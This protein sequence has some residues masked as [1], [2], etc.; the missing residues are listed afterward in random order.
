[1]HRSRSPMEQR[2]GKLF[3]RRHGIQPGLF[4]IVGPKVQHDLHPSPFGHCRV[5]SG[6]QRQSVEIHGACRLIQLHEQIGI[7]QNILRSPEDVIPQCILKNLG[8]LLSSLFFQQCPRKCQRHPALRRIARVPGTRNWRDRAH[9]VRAKLLRCE[10]GPAF[11]IAEFEDW[12]P[13]APK[14]DKDNFVAMIPRG[15]IGLPEEIATAALFLA[16]SDSSFI[17]GIELFVDGGVAQI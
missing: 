17:T 15:K 12:L 1:M 5:R 16:S 11:S 8:G 2:L 14:E 10:E 9:P 3:V 13:A 7:Q 4:T 6:F